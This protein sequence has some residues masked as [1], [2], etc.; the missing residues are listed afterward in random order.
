[1]RRYRLN[2]VYAVCI[3]TF[4]LTALCIRSI[5]AQPLMPSCP[6]HPA[7]TVGEWARLTVGSNLNLR[8]Q[9]TLK[10]ARL[11]VVR[12]GTMIEVIGEAVCA[13][14]YR[15]W[16]IRVG[17]GEHENQ[18]QDQHENQIEN[19]IEGWLADGDSSTIW[20][21]PRGILS[22]IEDTDGITRT[23]RVDADGEIIERAGCMR[24]PDDYSQ[25]RWGYV[26]LN[27]RT[28]AMLEQ[29]QRLYTQGGGFIQFKDRMVQGSYNPGVVAASFGTH[30]G[31]GAIDVSVRN[32]LDFSVQSSEIAPM[33]D[34]LRTAGFAAWLRAPN[35]LYQG[36][37]IHIH[38]VAVGD[39]E[40]SEAAQAQIDGTF[41]YLRGYN[42]LPQPEGSPPI[43]DIYGDPV[44]CQWMID[45]GIEDLR[46]VTPQSPVATQTP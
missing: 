6:D 41:G 17:G 8:P 37:M 34:A 38:A 43:A 9:P 22:D 42:G 1:M 18:E 27:R 35:E 29:A 45:D 44:I 2:P 4:L 12:E 26:T 7:L 36:S 15:W 32:P 28:V 14:G 13:E 24:P 16:Q 23:Y 21:E 30:D 33:L 20:I 5:H 10:L 39:L 31:G 40:A 19:Q 3:M 25:V 46:P 11:D